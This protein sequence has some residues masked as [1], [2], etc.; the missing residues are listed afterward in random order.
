MEILIRLES[1][2]L[3]GI[4]D[5]LDV[6]FPKVQDLLI[7]LRVP[8]FDDGILSTVLCLH[9]PLVVFKQHLVVVGQDRD[10]DLAQL[11]LGEVESEKV[12]EPR[13]RLVSGMTHAD[14]IQDTVDVFTVV[15]DVRQ[16]H[17]N[18]QHVFFLTV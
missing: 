7:T 6:V 14:R 18:F 2:L 3:V 10:D 5:P 11:V 12:Q 4:V 1:R 15:E 16:L 13:D 8:Q 17:H 9:H